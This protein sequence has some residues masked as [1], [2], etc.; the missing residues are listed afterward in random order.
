MFCPPQCKMT[1]ITLLVGNGE[2]LGWPDWCFML[3]HGFAGSLHYPQMMT[4]AWPKGPQGL[5][6]TH[7]KSIFKPTHADWL[8]CKQWLCLSSGP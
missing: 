1:Q 4:Q 5:S 7:Q 8:Q 6:K 3:P 2:P